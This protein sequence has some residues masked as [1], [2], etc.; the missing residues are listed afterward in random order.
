MSKQRPRFAIIDGD[1]LAYRFGFSAEDF[2]QWPNGATSVE[3]DFE[4]AI[5]ASYQW[6]QEV[7]QKLNA[8]DFVIALSCEPSSDCFRNDIYPEYKANRK[9]SRKPELWADV[10]QYLKENYRYIQR[11]KLEG[12]DVCGILATID[13][14]RPACPSWLKDWP[15]KDRVIVGMDKDFLTIPCRVYQPAM[16]WVKKAERR[17]V[18]DEESA[19][20]HH[21]F[22]TLAGDSVDNYRGCPYVG[23]Q[24]A[25]A[26]LDSALEATYEAMWP[27]V[28]EQYER[29]G[30]TE[31]DALLQARL[32]RILRAEDY[33]FKTKE[34]ILWDPK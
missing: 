16:E 5:E 8:E 4:K 34:V 25:H 10:R 21:M 24:R 12:D 19:A 3:V 9:N 11:P 18:V 13:P 26:V 20:Y 27:L 30:L 32:A 14:G 2:H 23:E 29:K 17:V 6:L 1:V 33:N 15:C 22:Q 28:V 7:T 31:D